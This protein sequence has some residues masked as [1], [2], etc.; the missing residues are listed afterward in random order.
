[1]TTP[2]TWAAP[3]RGLCSPT[4]TATARWKLPPPTAARWVS[5]YNLN[6]RFE[7]G[8]P[9]QP[10]SN[11]LR[12]LLVADLDGNNS[13]LEV[14]VTAA[15]GSKTSTWVLESNGST[16]AGW[17]QLSQRQRLRLGRVQRQRRRGQPQRQT[18]NWS[19]LFP[20]MCITST[21]S[22]R[23][24]CSLAANAMLRQQGLGQG[25][26]MGR[27]E[28]LKSV[29]GESASAG[30]PRSENYRPNFAHGPATLSDMNGD[31]TREVVAVGNVH[32]C[33]KDPYLDV[34]HGPYIF[35]ADRSRFNSGG[36]DWRS[37]PVDTGAPLSQDY[38][39]IES[40]QPNPVTADLD[41]DGLKEILYASYDGRMH[42][43]WLDKTEHHA[44]PYSVY[45]PAEG[46]L[47]FA[48]EPVVVDLENDGLAEV[49]FT[50]WV[51]KSTN[52]TGKLHILNVYG[53]PLYEVD[54]PA[55]FNG[56]WNGS[57]GA[58]TLA[59]VDTDADLEVVLMTAHSGVVVYD[60]PGT[61]NA[62]ILWG[63]GRGNYRRDGAP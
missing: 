26:H 24:E 4:S 47:R 56:N 52:R 54:L 57:L 28:L 29:A 39:L 41:G 13:N 43:F 8:W 27:L 21:A 30:L 23:R 3:G 7:A 32:D 9:K 59:N 19:S 10:S 12:G 45:K 62:R 5:V 16:R 60:L 51:Q 20:P 18:H 1:M 46:F 48:S 22:P 15:I 2:A 44:W 37:T 17:P 11:E 35:N 36:Y 50:S 40:A 33:S 6:G 61:Q 53:V 31:G 49:I 55:A 14:V 25:G 63:T 58:P 34:Y 38:N 42:V